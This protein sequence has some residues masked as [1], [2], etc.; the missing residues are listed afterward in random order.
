MECRSIK[1]P[2]EKENFPSNSPGE[3]NHR[4]ERTPSPMM[5]YFC[6]S[7]RNNDNKIQRVRNENLQKYSLEELHIGRIT[8]FGF[9]GKYNRSS[10]LGSFKKSTN[11]SQCG[12]FFLVGD[13]FK[14]QRRPIGKFFKK[15]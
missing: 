2:E 6:P 4:R 11:N 15:S 13:Q 5:R 12:F 8:F 9:V 7:Y 14:C 1:E 10:I 3:S